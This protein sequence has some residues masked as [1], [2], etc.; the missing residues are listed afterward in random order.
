MEGEVAVCVRARGHRR[1][2]ACTRELLQEVNV[3]GKDDRYMRLLSTETESRL[4]ILWDTVW[5]VSQWVEWRK[6]R[7]AENG[8]PVNAAHFRSYKDGYASLVRGRRRGWVVAP[9]LKPLSN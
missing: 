2:N 5:W 7:I 6:I 9:S 1:H 3:H 4:S 8:D